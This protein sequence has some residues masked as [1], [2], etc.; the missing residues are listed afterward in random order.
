MDPKE[1]RA[2]LVVL[3]LALGG[4]ASPGPTPASTPPQLQ[5]YYYAG[6]R[7]LTLKA[8]PDPAGANESQIRLN[9]AGPESRAPG[10]LVLGTASR[11]RPGR[12]GGATGILTLRGWLA[13]F[14]CGAGGC[15]PAPG[16][17]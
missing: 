17:G 13:G 15:E 9:E 11:R 14:T 5:T 16:S 10:F 4:C 12:L 8:T 3:L 6:V 7:E 1:L 2:L